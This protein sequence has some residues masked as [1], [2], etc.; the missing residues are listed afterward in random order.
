MKIYI[1]NIRQ[2]LIDFRNG[3]SGAVTV[4]AV[5]MLPLL[6]WGYVAMFTYFDAFRTKNTAEKAAYTIS[7]AMTRVTEGV[8]EDYIDGMKTLFDYLTPRNYPTELRVSE[9]QWVLQDPNDA[10]SP[11]DYE[12]RWS[13]GADGKAVMTNAMLAGL[14]DQLPNLVAG[15]RL[16]VV[17]ATSQWKPFFNV[18]LDARD[19]D[20]FVPTSPR[21][22]SQVAW[23]GASIYVGDHIGN[24]D[25]DGGQNHID[26]ED[27]DASGTGGWMGWGGWG[28]WGG[29]HSG[30][31]GGRG[32]Y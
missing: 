26:D 18:G 19:F 7:D 20:Y 30:H 28:G 25:A 23:E 16:V 22:S 17:E 14:S 6:A 24:A 31:S 3:T 12:V 21:F 4:E 8:D 11:G 32:W 5:L 27:D 2:R 10:N 29:G 15:E 13:Y 1:Q 9:I